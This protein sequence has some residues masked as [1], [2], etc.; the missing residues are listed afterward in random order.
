LVHE[1][2][3]YKFKGPDPGPDP[4]SKTAKKDTHGPKSEA[5]EI[6][7]VHIAFTLTKKVDIGSFIKA[8]IQIRPEKSN[9]DPQQFTRQ[10]KSEIFRQ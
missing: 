7:K 9:A 4:D 10:R 6:L 3:F 1:Y 5:T 8:S 2:T